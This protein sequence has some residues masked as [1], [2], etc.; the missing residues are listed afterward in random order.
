MGI[1]HSPHAPT[2]I[3]K[4]IPVGFCDRCNMKY[5]LHKLEWQKIWAGPSLIRTGFR[6]CPSCLDIANPNG[7]KPIR[8]YAD[9]RPLRDPRPGFLQVQQQSGAGFTTESGTQR[10]TESGAQFVADDD[11]NVGSDR[12][13]L[14]VSLLDGPDV[15]AP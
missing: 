4:P 11:G 6:V 10:T 3:S 7:K 13:I 8:F 1:T 12:F 5:H 14:G 2:S 15:L 9:P